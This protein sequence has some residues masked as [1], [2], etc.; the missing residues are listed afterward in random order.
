[1]LETAILSDTSASRSIVKGSTEFFR[2]PLHADGE[3][4]TPTFELSISNIESIRSLE[5]RSTVGYQY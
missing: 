3:H 5:S 1:V 4:R 2:F